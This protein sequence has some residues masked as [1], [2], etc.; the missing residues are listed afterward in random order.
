MM[1]HQMRQIKEVLTSIKVAN[2]KCGTKTK[3][4]QFKKFELTEVMLLPD[5]LSDGSRDRGI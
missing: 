2:K 4:T 1:I 3:A 5:P